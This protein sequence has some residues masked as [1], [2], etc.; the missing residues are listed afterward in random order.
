MGAFTPTGGP[1]SLSSASSG[2]KEEKVAQ[3]TRGERAGER[4]SVLVVWVCSLASIPFGSITES[5]FFLYDISWQCCFE[6]YQISQMLALSL[7]FVACEWLRYKKAT[8]LP[9]HL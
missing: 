3:K 8:I 6:Q 1:R 2:L 4:A 5:V 9:G 7:H